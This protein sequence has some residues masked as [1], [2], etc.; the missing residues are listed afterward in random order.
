MSSPVHVRSIRTNPSFVDLNDSLPTVA[1]NLW[2]HLGTQRRI[3]NDLRCFGD[4]V[5]KTPPSAGN[6]D[7]ERRSHSP[8]CA[9]NGAYKLICTEPSRHVPQ[10]ICGIMA[11]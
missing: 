2:H 10:I 5:M 8:I 6:V 9:S 3:G 4:T 1:S 11:M 7:A